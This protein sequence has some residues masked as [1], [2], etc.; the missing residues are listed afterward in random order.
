MKLSTRFPLLAFAGSNAMATNSLSTEFGRRSALNSATTT[1]MAQMEVAGRHTQ[2]LSTQCANESGQN[3]FLFRFSFEDGSMVQGRS[4]EKS[5]KVATAQGDYTSFNISI[6]CSDTFTNGYADSGSMMFNGDGPLEGVHPRV[7]DWEIMKCSDDDGHQHLETLCKSLDPKAR[8][9]KVHTGS[10]K[11]TKSYRNRNKKGKSKKG[12]D[13]FSFESMSYVTKKGSKG[14][15]NNKGKQTKQ[16][17]NKSK[18]SNKGDDMSRSYSMS[19]GDGNYVV[20]SYFNMSNGDPFDLDV[21][22][23]SIPE[24]ALGHE[25]APG[26]Y[27]V[28]DWEGEWDEA[29]SLRPSLASTPPAES[30][31]T[32]RDDSASTFS[33]ISS[34]TSL[35]LVAGAACLAAFSTAFLV[36]ALKDS[37]LLPS[38]S[39]RE[40]NDDETAFQVLYDGDSISN[41]D[42]GLTRNL[43]NDGASLF[44][45]RH[46]GEIIDDNRD[47]AEI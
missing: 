13:L 6:D 34:T 31:P 2:R 29:T 47:V 33:I 44:A 36:Y 16:K 8:R 15:H 20:H 40:A 5:I 27:P 46:F 4:S 7:V 30:Q 26:V 41:G 22:L 38:S 35:P 42:G 37:G 25:I 19:Y 10:A 17:M 21:V 32:S 3:A 14:P 24:H 12:E 1:L 28:V 43:E 11:A 23:K 45:T 9:T 39:R 18:K